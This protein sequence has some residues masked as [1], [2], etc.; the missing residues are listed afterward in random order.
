MASPDLMVFSAAAKRLAEMPCW[1]DTSLKDAELL[2][3]L[4]DYI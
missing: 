3:D 2:M 1:S 4:S